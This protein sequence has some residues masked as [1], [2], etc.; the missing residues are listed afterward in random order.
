MDHTHK[1]CDDAGGF[2]KTLLH[3]DESQDLTGA[4]SQIKFGMRIYPLSFLAF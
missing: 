3:P 4:R 1:A 2:K